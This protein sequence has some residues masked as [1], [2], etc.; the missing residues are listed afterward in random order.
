MTKIETIIDDI[1]EEITNWTTKWIMKFSDIEKILKKHLTP[2]K[3]ELV[4]IEEI[5]C[6]EARY[7]C[8]EACYQITNLFQNYEDSE[9]EELQIKLSKWIKENVKNCS[10]G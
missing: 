6:D 2:K 4:E 10:C 9:D 1:M 8:E 5:D 7:N 3:Q